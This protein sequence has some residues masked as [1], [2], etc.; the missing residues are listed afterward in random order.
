MCLCPLLWVFGLSSSHALDHCQPNSSFLLG[1]EKRTKKDDC[2]AVLAAAYPSLF[3]FFR[4]ASLHL[5][6]P[7]HLFISNVHSRTPSPSS[8][9]FSVECADV[10]CLNLLLFAFQRLLRAP[11]IGSPSCIQLLC[12][13]G[14]TGLWAS[15][16]TQFDNS[17]CFGLWH[18]VLKTL[19]FLTNHWEHEHPKGWRVI[20]IIK[21]NGWNFF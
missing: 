20:Q 7:P 11:R 18:K 6:P 16:R 10:T 4:F 19:T 17:T 2:T 21:Q 3:I 8:S 5:F 9:T 14:F 13:L 12:S 1:L 15:L